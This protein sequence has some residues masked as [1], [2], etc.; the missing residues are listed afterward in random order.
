MNIS[1]KVAYITGMAEG[2]KI[3][4]STNEGKITLAV[5]DVLKEISLELEE[6]DET[7]DDMAE[8]V[9]ELEEQVEEL[10]E[11]LYGSIDSSYDC[12]FENNLYEITCRNCD[13]SI[14]VDMSVLDSGS[15]KCPNC[16]G[17]IEFDI[18]F[19]SDESS[20]SNDDE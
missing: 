16:G 19:L 10:E 1:E 9:S 7:L 11:E 3:D 18:D 20:E 6:I 14:S 15:V 12:E 4:D 5:L 13:N 8:V 17:K 2:M